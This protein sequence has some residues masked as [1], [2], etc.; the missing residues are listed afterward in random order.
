MANPDVARQLLCAKWTGVPRS[1]AFFQ[2][3]L[4]LFASKHYL[5]QILVAHDLFRDSELPTDRTVLSSIALAA[6][7]QSDTETETEVSERTRRK[8]SGGELS[9]KDC[10]SLFH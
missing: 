8:D 7:E 4:K 6:A 3:V 5:S 2:S 9:G 10:V 1:L